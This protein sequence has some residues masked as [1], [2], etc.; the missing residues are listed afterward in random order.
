MSEI[1]YHYAAFLPP[2]N[3]GCPICGEEMHHAKRCGKA[4][5]LVCERHCQSCEEYDNRLSIGICKFNEDKP[6][7]EDAEQARRAAK[8]KIELRGI[9]LSFAKDKRE[10]IV[11]APWDGENGRYDIFSEKEAFEAWSCFLMRADK[12]GRFEIKTALKENR[13]AQITA[14]LRGVDIHRSEGGVWY[15]S[16]EG[17]ERV[18]AFTDALEAWVCF[19][20]DLDCVVRKS[21][22]KTVKNF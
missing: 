2:D 15:V 13:Q 17:E 1:K 5:A 11:Y 9:E 3:R 10:Y 4:A 14:E 22:A 20:Q 16:R 6:R 8:K 12:S 21:I 7:I 19:I 18:E